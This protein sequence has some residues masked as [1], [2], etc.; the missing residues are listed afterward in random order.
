MLRDKLRQQ[1]IGND[2]T[3]SLHGFNKVIKDLKVD[4]ADV[5]IKNV[6]KAFDLE[7]KSQM[8]YD[9]FVKVLVGPMN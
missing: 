3:I 1:D 4:V 5:D 8:F 6:F 2:G 9:E 7:G